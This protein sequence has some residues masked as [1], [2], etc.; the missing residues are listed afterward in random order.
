MG[1][2]DDLANTGKVIGQVVNGE[3][4]PL[5]L[6]KDALGENDDE[7]PA[8]ATQRTAEGASAAPALRAVPKRVAS[9]DPTK[10]S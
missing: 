3:K 5:D 8:P 2:I 9:C 6:V 7:T 1:L 10:A 4:T